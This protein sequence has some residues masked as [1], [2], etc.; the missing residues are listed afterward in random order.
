[1]EPL[2]RWKHFTHAVWESTDEDHIQLAAI[3]LLDGRLGH[4][5]DRLI[6]G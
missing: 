5:D 4:V 1:M 3:Y 6:D 2:F